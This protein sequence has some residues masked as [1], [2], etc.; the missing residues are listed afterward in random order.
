MNGIKQ[1]LI[2]KGYKYKYTDKYG[3]YLYK[4]IGCYC[5]LAYINNYGCVNRMTVNN[6]LTGVI[7]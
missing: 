2:D 5:Y 6:Y 1:I 4:Y 7:K 3:M